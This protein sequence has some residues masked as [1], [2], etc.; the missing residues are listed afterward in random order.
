MYYVCSLLLPPGP[1][2][3]ISETADHNKSSAYTDTNKM[4]GGY[5]SIDFTCNYLKNTDM[6]AETA[7]AKSPSAHIRRVVIFHDCA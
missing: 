4:F 3:N 6:S 7:G 1:H 2:G 5:I